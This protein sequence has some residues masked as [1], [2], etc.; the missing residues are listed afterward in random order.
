MAITIYLYCLAEIV[1]EVE[2][3][4][5]KAIANSD[6]GLCSQIKLPMTVETFKGQKYYNASFSM[7]VMNEDEEGLYNLYFHS[8]PNYRWQTQVEIDFT[9]RNHSTK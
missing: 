9:V 3:D 7:R 6:G 1:P 8:C 2:D 5:D 4:E